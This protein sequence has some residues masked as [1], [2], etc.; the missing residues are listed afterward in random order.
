MVKS[1]APA[2]AANL[3]DFQEKTNWIIAADRLCAASWPTPDQGVRLAGRHAQ[4]KKP[5]K[6]CE[7]RPLC[8][9]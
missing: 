8:V 1:W 2:T 5:D 3:F 7:R 9:F 6:S 4:A